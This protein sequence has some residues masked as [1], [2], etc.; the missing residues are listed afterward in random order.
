MGWGSGSG[1]VKESKDKKV[2]VMWDQLAMV[3]LGVLVL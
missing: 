2:R 3:R 1:S